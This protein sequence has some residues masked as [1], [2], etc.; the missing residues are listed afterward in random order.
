MS[1]DIIYLNNAATS[2]P[3]PKPV[4][5]RHLWALTEL[6]AAPGRAGSATLE[7]ERAIFEAREEVAGF[8]GA[9]DS[10]RVI[11]TPNGTAALNLAI[12]GLVESGDRV[13]TTSMDHNS[14][15]RPLARAEEENEIE[16]VRVPADES[17]GIQASRIVEE[18][19]D[20]TRL[21]I[22]THASNVTGTIQPVEE[23]C[24]ALAAL[25]GNRPFVL[26]DAAQSAGVIPIDVR[27]SGI[28]LLAA[29]GHKSLYGP[30]GTGFLYIGEGIDLVPIMEGG[31]GDQST[32]V[33]QP[34]TLPDRYESGTPNI[35]GI[36]AFGEAV[37]FISG[38][39]L[40]AIREHENRLMEILIGGLAEIEGVN[41]FG[42]CR[43]DRQVAVLS[44]TVEGMD[45]A[46]VGTYLER[47]KGVVT[48]VGLHCSPH[49]HRSIGTYPEGTVRASP[50]I[51]NTES[52]I[53]SLVEGVVEL[54]GTRSG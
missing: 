41:L 36:V 49:S 52:D 53:R 22:L 42:P 32:L 19:D 23:V 16:V 21:V 1:R 15:A 10:S 45:P 17:G 51:F 46:E 37:K 24:S 4:V 38:R 26:V 5:D 35:P 43:S 44:F 54:A 12:G 18:V 48:R 11:F 2:W 25:G 8:I 7:C 6:L 20:R 28:D 40:D 3:K 27:Q 14:V 39:G 33:R 30:Q 9:P 29:P 47:V 31:T 13:V 50:G 34:P